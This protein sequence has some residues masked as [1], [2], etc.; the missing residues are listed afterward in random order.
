M[1]TMTYYY[2]A[3]VYQRQAGIYIARENEIGEIFTHTAIITPY[4][5][6]IF[7]LI[8]NTNPITT[9]CLQ[10]EDFITHSCNLRHT[11]P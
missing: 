2:M 10:Y 9:A 3:C 8:L 7:Q 1:P 5:R 11:N 6:K 4:Q